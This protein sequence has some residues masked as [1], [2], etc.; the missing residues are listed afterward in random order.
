MA[1]IRTAQHIQT[2][3]ISTDPLIFMDI[4][5]L[6]KKVIYRAWQWI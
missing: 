3:T 5:N 1:Y 6:Q 4:I 2:R